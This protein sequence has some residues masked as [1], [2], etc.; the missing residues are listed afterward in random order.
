MYKK[1]TIVTIYSYLSPE[2]K[3]YGWDR[4]NGQLQ[5]VWEVPENLSKV[6][7]TLDFAF[8]GCKCKQVVVHDGANVRKEIEIVD[9][10][11]NALPGK[12]C[13][14]GELIQNKTV[15]KTVKY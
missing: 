3:D 2:L 1:H 9:V 15:T 8:S 5:V 6:Q 4:V 13:R 12:T 14:N 11:V 7:A 10:L